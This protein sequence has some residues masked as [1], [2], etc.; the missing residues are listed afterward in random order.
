MLCCVALLQTRLQLRLFLT[1]VKQRASIPDHV[2]Y[3][4]L[5]TSISVPKLASFLKTDEE[6]AV[7]G[8]L[9]MKNK[10]RSVPTPL[11]FQAIRFIRLTYFGVMW[12]V[13]L[14]GGVAAVPPLALW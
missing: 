12:Y 11:C 10:T 5:C 13:V 2:S 7:Q 9:N 14:C 1:D 3:L 6:S 4:K 8:L